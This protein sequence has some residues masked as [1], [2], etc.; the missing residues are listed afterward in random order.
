LN[1]TLH[2]RLYRRSA[3]NLLPTVPDLIHE[4]YRNTSLCEGLRRTNG[5]AGVLIGLNRRS[6]GVSRQPAYRADRN[7]LEISD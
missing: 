1:R 2:V 5:N 6:S 3:S 4:D 7:R